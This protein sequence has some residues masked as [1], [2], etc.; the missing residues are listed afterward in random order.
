MVKKMGVV[1]LT[2]ETVVFSSN[3]IIDSTWIVINLLYS[4]TRLFMRKLPKK[5]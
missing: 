3:L 1:F 4:L 5:N 2:E